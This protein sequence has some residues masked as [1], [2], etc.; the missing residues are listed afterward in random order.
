MKAYYHCKPLTSRRCENDGIGELWNR[1][2]IYGPGGSRLA[3]GGADQAA[4]AAATV[5]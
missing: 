4:V 3:G 2:G 1:A 5:A